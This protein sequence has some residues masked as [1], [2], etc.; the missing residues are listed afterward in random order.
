VYQQRASSPS[1]QS[2]EQA[3][4]SELLVTVARVQKYIE[5][6]SPKDGSGLVKEVIQCAT[7]LKRTRLLQLNT[8]LRYL[9]SEATSV[10]NSGAVRQLSLRLS[11][12]YREL[13]TIDSAM[14]LHG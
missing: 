3:V 13:R 5:S 4:P 9:I 8:E 6:R 14:H 7:R 12:L 1:L 10:G 11:E 2:V